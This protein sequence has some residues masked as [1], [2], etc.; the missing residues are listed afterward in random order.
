[1]TALRDIIVVLEEAASSEIRLT[2]AIAL[3]QQHNAYLIGLS[4]LNLL[5]PAR[6]VVQPRDPL[7]TDASPTASLLLAATLTRGKTARLRCRTARTDLCAAEAGVKE[8]SRRSPA[9]VFDGQGWQS[10]NP[11]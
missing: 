4:A 3:A 7:E 8:C 1:M 5:T 2:A 11:L 6:P 10:A 9:V